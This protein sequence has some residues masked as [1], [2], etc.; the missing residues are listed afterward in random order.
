MKRL[1]HA[2]TLIASAIVLSACGATSSE[3][4]KPVTFTQKTKTLTFSTE[5][6]PVNKSEV[7]SGLKESALNATG[8]QAFGPKP[9]L[10]GYSST[11]DR[12]VIVKS[13]SDGLEVH[14]VN[15]VKTD[16][17]NFHSFKV[18]IFAIEQNNQNEAAVT[19][20]VTSPSSLT[21]RTGKA[22]FMSVDHLDGDQNIV[23]DLQA[24]HGNLD[25]SIGV[26]V[27]FSGEIKSEFDV[28]AIASNFTRLYQAASR[29]SQHN[30]VL[31][32][33]FRDKSSN[34]EFEVKISPY[35]NGSIT[36]YNFL[37]ESTLYSDGK[38]S[39]SRDEL[40]SIAE[41]LTSSISSAVNA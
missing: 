19:F 12:G 38:T 37:L 36:K 20:Q 29:P 30:G 4:A 27:P 26:S 5:F 23:N 28:N 15:R 33:T 35:R 9:I 41:Q 3:P 17:G 31:T 32:Q 2:A 24:I 21:K 16:A 10:T 7:V 11:Y 25:T 8:Y 1:F 39:L 18:G 40:D 13:G 6:G 22:L 34:V 14:Y